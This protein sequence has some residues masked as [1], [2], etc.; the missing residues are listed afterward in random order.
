MRRG[1]EPRP[2]RENRAGRPR[3]A[4]KGDAGCTV[5]GESGPHA[6]AGPQ[7]HQAVAVVLDLVDPAGSDWRLEAGSR[8][9]PSGGTSPCGPSAGQGCGDE[10]RAPIPTASQGR[11]H[12]GCARVSQG[13]PEYESSRLRSVSIPRP[14]SA[15]PGRLRRRLDHHRG[16]VRVGRSRPPPPPA[17]VATYWLPS[18]TFAVLLALAH[19]IA[20][21]KAATTA[22]DFTA[23][24]FIM[25]ILISSR[26]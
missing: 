6:L 17:D 4:G 15:S 11:R 23:R 9:A 2:G 10:A 18:T 22:K 25:R 13:A 19:V 7:G 5:A 21:S 20:V 1:A 3:W 26:A 24:D 16:G 14:C 12:T 8:L